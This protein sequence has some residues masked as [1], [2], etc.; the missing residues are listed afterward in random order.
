MKNKSTDNIKLGAFVISGVAFLIFMLY[1]IGR[2]QNLFQSTYTLK[3]HITNAQ[4]LVPGN[5]VRYAGIEIG[6]VQKI[7]F[8][9]DTLIE[10]SLT[11]NSKMSKIIK[12][13]AI[14]SVGSEGLVGNKVLNI[15]YSGQGGEVA[16]EG[17]ILKGTHMVS[18]DDM[19]AILEKTN[20]DVAVVAAGMRTSIERINNSKAIWKIL[21]D[22]KS[23]DNIQYAMENLR[24]ASNNAAKFLDDLKSVSASLADGKG[25]I[26]MLL[27]DTAAVAD[28]QHSLKQFRSAAD[29]IDSLTSS[30]NRYA[31]EF[32][33]DIEK[34]N[35][36]FNVL[37]KDSILAD[38]LKAS[39]NSIEKG[40]ASF[41]TNM[42]A[43]RHNFLFRRYFRKLEKQNKKVQ[44]ENSVTMKIMQNE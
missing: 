30:L 43:L 3:A 44:P 14:V 16:S 39:M 8:L 27:S 38:K 22:S 1:M 6:T 17:D 35:N 20:R 2:N 4:G 19:L 41:T 33:N 26:G 40:T 37:L 42:E 21:D 29:N 28:V 23:A 9:N 32:H 31:N 7:K 18:A 11:I 24:M 36:T 13:N 15:S 5:N 10:I 34:G 12:K 25:T